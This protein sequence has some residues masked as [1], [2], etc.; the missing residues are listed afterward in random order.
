MKSLPGRVVARWRQLQARERKLAKWCGAILGIVLLFTIHGWQRS[1]RLRLQKSLPLAEARLA[2]ME[3]MGDQFV[4]VSAL[5]R[6]RTKGPVPVDLL[7]ISLK[8]HGLPMELVK[9]GSNQFSVQGAV[10]FDDWVIWLAT[11]AA[12]GWRV[13]RATV[14]FQ[15]PGSAMPQALVRVDA[16]L[17]AVGG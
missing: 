8:S 9:T 6:D 10:V 2:S 16:T 17:S 14:Q 13:E 7:A 4:S 11:A 3:A 12:Q 15:A 5:V 1:E